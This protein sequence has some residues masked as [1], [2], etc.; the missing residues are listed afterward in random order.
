MGQ[1]LVQRYDEDKFW[2]T[3]SGYRCKR[4]VDPDT[5]KSIVDWEHPVF[6]DLSPKLARYWKNKQQHVIPE[7]DHR[8]KF[9]STKEPG[10]LHPFK[11]YNIIPSNPGFHLRLIGLSGGEYAHQN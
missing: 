11:L 7:I 8:Q 5:G 1:V 4:P 6:V 3:G 10:A 9:F 2:N